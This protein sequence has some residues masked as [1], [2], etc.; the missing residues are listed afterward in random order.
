M[1][2]VNDGGAHYYFFEHA[3]WDG[4]YVADLVFPWLVHFTLQ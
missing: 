2:F 3:A 1:I 4:L